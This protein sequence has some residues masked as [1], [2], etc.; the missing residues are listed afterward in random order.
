MSYLQSLQKKVAKNKGGN[1]TTSTYGPGPS[2][3][4]MAELDKKWNSM[5]ASKRKKLEKLLKARLEQE[6]PERTASEAR[7]ESTEQNRSIHQAKLREQYKKDKEWQDKKDQTALQ[8]QQKE[9][10]AARDAE[11]KRRNAEIKRKQDIKLDAGQVAVDVRRSNQEINVLQRDVDKLTKRIEDVKDQNNPTV[12]RWKQER[13]DM[14][15]EIAILKMEMDNK[16]VNLV[17]AATDKYGLKEGIEFL[18][19]MGI[20][21]KKINE[22]LSRK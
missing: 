3:E 9:A 21:K 18:T 16:L 6:S 15:E 22:I 7:D 17:D 8:N 11:I 10:E 5:P 1:Y 19:Q 4:E 13:A 2:E 14:V 20:D 12:N